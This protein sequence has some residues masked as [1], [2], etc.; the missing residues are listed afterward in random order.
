MRLILPDVAAVVAVATG[1]CMANSTIPRRRSMPLA[2]V[3]APEATSVDGGSILKEFSDDDEG[4]GHAYGHQG[5]E[6][7]PLLPFL[8]QSGQKA[9]GR[10]RQRDGASSGD[11]G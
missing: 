10:G 9:S 4:C 2:V 5:Y 3:T 7:Q 6:S 11:T 1:I 8:A